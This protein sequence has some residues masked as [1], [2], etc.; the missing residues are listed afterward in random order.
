MLNYILPVMVTSVKKNAELHSH[1]SGSVI[2]LLIYWLEIYSYW[3][4][5]VKLLATGIVCRNC[6]CFNTRNHPTYLPTHQHLVSIMYIQCYLPTHSATP[7][8]HYVYTMQA[9][10]QNQINKQWRT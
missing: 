6:V 2:L 3:G 1:D 4:K 9:S 10:N 8:Y 7:L 5:Y